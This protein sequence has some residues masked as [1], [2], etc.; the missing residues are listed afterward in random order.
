[1]NKLVAFIKSKKF[2]VIISLGFLLGGYTHCVNPASSPKKKQLAMT[3]N[4]QNGSTSTN[5]SGDGSGVDS[6]G[7]FSATLHPI[8]QMRCIPCHNSFS[9]TSSCRT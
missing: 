1:M 9:T 5:N 2:M 4:S 6:V 7:I 8:T 3:D